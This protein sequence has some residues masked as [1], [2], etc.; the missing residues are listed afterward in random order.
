MKTVFEKLKT[1]N[2]WGG[3]TGVLEAQ[4]GYKRDFYLKKIEQYLGNNLIKVFVGQRRVGKSVLMMQV[5]HELVST[6]VPTDNIFY[7]NKEIIDFDEIKTARDLREII[8]LYKKEIR[9]EG[10]VYYFFDELQ[11][12]EEWEKMVNSLAQD[13]AHQAEVFISGS[14]SNMLSSELATYLTGRYISFEIFPFSYSEY[15]SYLKLA[16]NKE[17]FLQ[18][19]RSSGL[20]EFFKLDTNEAKRNYLV[21]LK[22]SI[23]L[24]DI[25][26]RYAIKDVR[27]LDKIL[28]FVS[29][30]IGN[31]FSVASIEK[32]LR[33]KNN[34]ISFET[35]SNY[36]SYLLQ[37][38]LIHEVE[39]FDIKGKSILESGKKYFLNDLAFRNY[40]FST[41]DPGLGGQLENVIFLYLRRLGYTVYVGKLGDREVDFIA[42]K[43]GDRQYIQVAYSVADE[44]VAKREF[45]NLKKI[46]DNFE[47]IVVS[48]DDT[49]FGNDSG[50]RHMTAWDFLSR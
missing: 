44:Q 15:I 24:K 17:S 34:R 36:L 35:V 39:R 50:I 22:D 31:T 48:L 6:G 11:D 46:K 47:K 16:N 37:T 21:T 32:Y 18:Y 12:I 3:A 28:D 26:G 20:P 4:L 45:G 13:S 33:S 42:E 5:M 38:F 27:F 29:D 8:A 7:L 30:N 40:V 49:S 43:D 23:L 41:F 14:N 10:K 19:L 1:Y 25:V 2:T 9:P